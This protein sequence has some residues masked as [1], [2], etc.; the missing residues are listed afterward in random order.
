MK[1]STIL[2]TACVFMMGT[3]ASTPVSYAAGA[4]DFL[5][6]G[7]SNEAPSEEQGFS[8][9][10]DQTYSD[11]TEDDLYQD[12]TGTGTE[13]DLVSGTDT[14][15][16][17]YEKPAKT[18]KITTEAQLLGLASLVNENQ[19]ESWKPSRLENFEG[20][21]FILM[22]DIKLTG[23][24]TPVGSG[25]ASY[26][27]GTFDGN[28]HTIS[29]MVVDPNYEYSGF[30]GYLKGQ[31]KNLNIEGQIT[32]ESDN[33]GGIA[34]QIEKESRFVNCTSSVI[35][36]G[37]DKTGGIVG[38][39][40]GGKIEMSVNKGNVYGTYKVGGVVGENWAG[41]IEQCANMGN[42]TS[43]QRGVATYGT[44]G[45]AG[46]SVSADSVVTESYNIGKITSNTEAT[47]GVVGYTNAAGAS[48][49]SCYSTGEIVIRGN[50]KE[51]VNSWVGGVVGIVG[52]KGITI[53]SC[54][55][56]KGVTGADVT[57]GVVGRYIDDHNDINENM[58]NKNYYVSD[59]YDSGI[60]QTE[61]NKKISDAAL[62]VS[63]G[64][65]NK[66]AAAL[67][68]AYISD[69]SG[70]YGNHGFPVLEWQSPVSE[71]ERTYLTVLSKDV[72]IDFDEYL[73]ETASDNKTG[74]SMLSFLNPNSY[75]TNAASQYHADKMEKE[76][77]NEK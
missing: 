49:T 46:R 23:K 50:Q 13:S 11:Y 24:W 67:G 58:I 28:N 8:D 62:G 69:S 15:W 65:L 26:F 55:A 56:A 61:D 37:R 19:T 14:T 21:T 44:G 1:R 68:P 16:F 12:A 73:I 30:F 38:Y 45:V 2:L 17:N 70:R 32:S 10:G 7:H 75:I 72:Q 39:N 74:W 57:G 76:E 66:M 5:N 51:V 47:G 54:Y 59:F 29:G 18:Y 71:E 25:S 60:G 64:G 27:A 53:H 4:A 43:T 48:I 52:C 40:N 9:D 35:I 63:S 77:Q 20:V 6:H 42:V 36:K 22:N 33:T 3:I 31:V 34:G 41:T